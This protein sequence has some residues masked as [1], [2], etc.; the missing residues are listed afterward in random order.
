[1]KFSATI[2]T[3]NTKTL[4]K[5]V[6]EKMPPCSRQ[7]KHI[8]TKF[9]PPWSQQALLFLYLLLR[10]IQPQHMA[11]IKLQPP[12][13]Q[14]AQFDLWRNS[15]T[16]TAGLLIALWHSMCWQWIGFQ[17]A[18]PKHSWLLKEDIF[19]LSVSSSINREREPFVYNKYYTTW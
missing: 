9:W 18:K 16:F 17:A 1:M 8:F 13:P 10:C 12:I 15:S 7:P 6:G 19:I 5:A 11:E 4:S 3:F 2:L 14:I